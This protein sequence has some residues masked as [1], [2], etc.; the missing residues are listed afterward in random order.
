MRPIVLGKDDIRHRRV[1]SVHERLRRTLHFGVTPTVNIR[2][3]HLRKLEQGSELLE[4]PLKLEDYFVKGHK[5]REVL[6]F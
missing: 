2:S 1:F 5:E 4:P 3:N 6:L